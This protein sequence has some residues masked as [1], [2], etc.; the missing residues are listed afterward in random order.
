MQDVDEKFIKAEYKGDD[1]TVKLLLKDSRAD[2][3][4]DDNYPVRNASQNGYVGTV[5][6]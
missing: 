2:P 5:K 3:T 6:L 1:K 4:V